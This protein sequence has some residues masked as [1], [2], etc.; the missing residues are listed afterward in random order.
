MIELTLKPNYDKI[1]LNP[2]FI[3]W[4][5]PYTKQKSSGTIVHTIDEMSWDVVETLTDINKKIIRG[6]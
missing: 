4:M 1:V 2:K 6:Y 3:I 5:K